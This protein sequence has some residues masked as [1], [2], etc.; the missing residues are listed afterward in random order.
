ME[1]IGEDNVGK[2]IVEVRKGFGIGKVW[3]GRDW[4]RKDRWG[5]I[6]THPARGLG[7]TNISH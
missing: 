2:E 4:E 6:S 7:W 3:K 1:R 5:A